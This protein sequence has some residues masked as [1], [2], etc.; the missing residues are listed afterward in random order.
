MESGGSI[1]Q[2]TMLFNTSTGKTRPMRNK[3]EA[4]DYR[5]F[6]DPDLLPLEISDE[7]IGKIKSSIPEL[8]DE[9]KN[10]FIETY[11]LS[12]YDA[13]VLT[14]EKQT[15]DYFNETINSDPELKNH[16]KIVVNWIT[17]E[18]FSLL[19][20]NNLELNNS[21]VSPENLGQLVKLI[22]INEISGKIAKDVLE[23]MFTSRKT[24]KEIV[25]EKGLK[26]VTDQGEIE[27]VIE[28]VISDNPK[29]VEEYLGGKDKLLGFFVGQ[30][31]QKT[32]GKANPKILNEILKS[33]LK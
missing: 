14:A 13:S 10:R 28:E 27:K 2:N 15:S 31:M 5:Y 11:K 32:K 30:A 24:A 22:C 8:P 12:N 3:E 21:P 29:M 33:K 1:E 19:N 9:L 18:L 20:K 6:P 23:D 4:H 26:Q 25:D 7:E 16:A 17:S